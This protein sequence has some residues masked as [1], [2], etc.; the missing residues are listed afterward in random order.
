MCQQITL[1]KNVTISVLFAASRGCLNSLETF[2]PMIRS[3]GYIMLKVPS[4]KASF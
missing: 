4:V 1:T 2:F 3:P